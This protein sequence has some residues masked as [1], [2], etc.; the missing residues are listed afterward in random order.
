MPGLPVLPPCARAS[1]PGRRSTAT[2]ATGPSTAR[3]WRSLFAHVEA[4]LL[5]AGETPLSLDPRRE[6]LERRLIAAWTDNLNPS[7]AEL[8]GG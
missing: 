3:I 7:N 2:G 6:E 8:V 1:A 5:A 4:E